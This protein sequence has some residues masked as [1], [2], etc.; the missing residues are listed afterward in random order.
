MVWGDFLPINKYGPH[1]FLKRHYFQARTALPMLSPCRTRGPSSLA[2]DASSP[3]VWYLGGATSGELGQATHEG[4]GMRNCTTL[5]PSTRSSTS[6]QFHSNCASSGNLVI[7][8][9]NSSCFMGLKILF[10]AIIANPVS[11]QGCDTKTIHIV[12]L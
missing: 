3:F 5:L 10:Y 12:L 9:S 8:D 7:F 4:C 2:Y 1:P 6:R 11:L